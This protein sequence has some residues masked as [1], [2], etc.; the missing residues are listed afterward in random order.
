MKSMSA[1]IVAV[2]LLAA[3]LPA[4]AQQDRPYPEGAAP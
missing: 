4:Q 1:T 3:T 2:A